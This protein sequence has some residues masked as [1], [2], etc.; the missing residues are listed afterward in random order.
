MTAA[1]RRH[2]ILAATLL[3]P[4]VVALALVGS[5]MLWLHGV[6]LPFASGAVWFK[7]T[8][9]ASADYSS[10]PDR[11]VFILAIGN[12]GRPGDTSTRGDA[13]HLIGVNPAQRKATMLDF[14][15][16]LGLPIPGHGM[17][18]VNISHVYGGPRL[19]AQT[20]GNAVGVQIPYAIDTNFPGFISMVDDMGGLTVNVPERM[21]D[22]NSGANF[23]A[24]PNHFDGHQALSFAR[25]R[26][27]FPTGDLKRSENQ[28]YLIIQALA[29]LRADNTGP[30]GTL[31]LLANL[32]RH[33]ELVGIGIDDLYDL[34]RLGLSIDPGN[35]RN[36][37]V[38]IS[39]GSGSRL[40]LGPGAGSL[41][42][43]FAD[44]AVLQSH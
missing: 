8:K 26:H 23:E 20:I 31:K 43:D 19:E 35:V 29:Q 44:D 7:V 32:G 42:A 5:F 16:D 9:T 6:R 15:R 41:F 25:N 27:Q 21:H 34:G 1:L 2:P 33:A 13:I 38:P 3:A 17:D 10:T 14:P 37:V 39:A 4:L 22:P 30:I 18:K 12:D 36:V 28:G 11:P 24:G 40:S